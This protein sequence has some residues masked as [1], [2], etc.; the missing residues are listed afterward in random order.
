MFDVKAEC[1][2]LRGQTAGDRNY[3][4]AHPEL[5]G[6]EENTLSWVQGRLAELGLS[7]VRVEHGGLVCVLNGREPGRRLLLRADVDALPVEESADN[8]SGPKQM[9]SGTA[10][11]SHACGHDAH[12]AMLLSA[13]QVLSAHREEWTGQIVA[14]FEQGEETSY[15]VIPLLEHLEAQFDGMDGCFALH[16]YAGSPA[17]TLSVQ[18]GHVMCGA[19]GFDVVLTGKGGHSSRP[20]LC[21]NPVDCFVSIYNDLAA[22]RMRHTDPNDC[23]TYAVGLL[24]GGSKSN[25]IPDSLRFSCL[26]RFFDEETCGRPFLEAAKTIV[27]KDAQIYD[28]QVRYNYIMEPIPGV[29]NDPD[30]AALA[31]QSLRRTLGEEAV[32]PAGPWMASESMA[33]YNTLYRGVLAFLGIQDRQGCGAPHHS[34]EFDLDPDLLYLGAGAIVSYAMD[35]LD[36]G[37]TPPPR[38]PSA[39]VLERLKKQLM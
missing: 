34:G 8:L 32:V 23:L 7:A 19:A 38:K 4:H 16:V 28:C 39:G 1:L 5:S 36:P 21:N 22:V 10:G 29:Y 3:L 18:P 35:F 17:G 25:I 24:Q 12:T 2:A 9:V 14:V 11:V 37:F 30:C 33:V 15:G 31:Q 27:E 13:L 6:Q 26:A 20:D